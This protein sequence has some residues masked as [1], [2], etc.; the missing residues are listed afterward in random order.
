MYYLV[1]T[2]QQR[3]LLRAALYMVFR[4]IHMLHIFLTPACYTTLA[5]VYLSQ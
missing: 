2:A 5:R 3:N 4:G 1:R